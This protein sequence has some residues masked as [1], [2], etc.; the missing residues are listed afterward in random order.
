M[1]ATI[2]PQDDKRTSNRPAVQ[3]VINAEADKAI[4]AVLKRYGFAAF[5]L[6]VLSMVGCGILYWKFPHNRMFGQYGL[7]FDVSAC[8]WLIPFFAGQNKQSALRVDFGRRYLAEGRFKEAAAA[9]GSFAE[10]GQRSFD[11]TGEAHFLLAQALDKVGKKEKAEQARQFVIKHRAGT[12]W[13]EKLAGT[14]RIPAAPSAA[15]LRRK[16]IDSTGELV[17]R[18]ATS[19]QAKTRRRRF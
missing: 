10:F 5:C 9:L 1:P 13:A 7:I 14:A 18:K 12:P 17:G 16:S 8:L 19:G 4:F 2:A 15:Q 3:H 6:A 11:R